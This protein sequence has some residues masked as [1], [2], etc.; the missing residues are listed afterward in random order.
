M[1]MSFTASAVLI[2]VALAACSST[3]QYHGGPEYQVAFAW[4]VGK[5][6]QGEVVTVA[7]PGYEERLPAEGMKVSFA[8]SAPDEL[9]V[10]LLS[11]NLA[12]TDRGQRRAEFVPMSVTKNPALLVVSDALDVAFK[13]LATNETLLQQAVDPSV[14]Y[15]WSVVRSR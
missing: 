5:K 4:K 13:S 8:C 10:T 14:R 3:S 2:A 15:K 12:T 7:C 11:L 1:K 6:V 9:D